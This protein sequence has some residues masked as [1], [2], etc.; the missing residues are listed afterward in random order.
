[1]SGSE[2]NAIYEIEGA[3]F[4][5]QRQYNE[6]FVLLSDQKL[7]L[8][9]LTS[10]TGRHVQTVRKP[11]ERNYAN[12]NH[13]PSPRTLTA[14]HLCLCF[15]TVPLVDKKKQPNRTLELNDT[16]RRMTRTI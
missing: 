2:E 16:I 11:T 13:L 15:G 5:N 6:G 8:L 4:S 1:M 7:Y 10:K 3:R 14:I 9:S 12:V